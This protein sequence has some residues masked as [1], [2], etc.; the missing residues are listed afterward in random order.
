MTSRGTCYRVGDLSVDPGVRR[1]QRG[2]M[3]LPVRGLSF[4]LLLALMDAAPNLLSIDELMQRVWPGVVVS[5][6]TVSQRIKL[7]RHA[8]GDHPQHARYIVGVRGRG[9]RLLAPVEVIPPPQETPER[10]AHR[11]PAPA[12]VTAPA[13]ATTTA[14]ATPTTNAGTTAGT[15]DQTETSP[16]VTNSG[17]RT[18]AR[19]SL[20]VLA[21]LLAGIAIAIGFTTLSNTGAELNGERPRSKAEDVV[22]PVLA[23]LPFDAAGR[24]DADVTIPAG[25]HADVIREL[26]RVRSIEVIAHTSVS[27]FKDTSL[28]TREIGLRLGAT[29]LLEGN[30]RQSGDRLRIQA[31]LIEASTERQLWADTYERQ[32][33]ATNMF[34]AQ[35]QIA[36]AVANAL[37]VSATAAEQSAAAEVPTRN[38]D[39]WALEKTARVQLARRTTASITA[40]EKLFREAIAIDRHYARAYAGLADAIWLKAD[41]AGLPWPPA[42]AE[43]ERLAKVALRI[44]PDLPE[45]LTTLAKIAE[46]QLDYETAEALYRRVFELNPSY[47][48]AHT[49]YSQLMYQQGRE[50]E[51]RESTKR[52][53]ALDP[54]S[55]PLRVNMGL[56]VAEPDDLADAIEWMENAREIEPTSPIGASGMAI[57]FAFAGRYDEALGW[58]LAALAL[59]PQAAG[60]LFGAARMHLELDNLDGA[61]TWFAHALEKGRNI[62]DTS[63][64]AALLK[65]Y[66]DA[67]SDAVQLARHALSISPWEAPAF[68]VLNADAFR[69]VDSAGVVDAVQSSYPELFAP[70]KPRVRRSSLLPATD[71]ALA[72]QRIGNTQRAGELLAA[73]SAFLD[74]ARRNGSREYVID[75]I[76]ID[77]IRRQDESALNALEELVATGWR[78]PYWRFYRDH[79]AAFDALRADARFQKAFAV[80]EQEIQSQRSRAN[81]SGALARMPTES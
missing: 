48:M 21:A 59:E 51:A 62:P 70:G 16:S 10:V 28:R 14:T 23:V 42:R 68:M 55:A 11:S 81:R 22:R 45:A 13:P 71:L 6:E 80:V 19:K 5:P 47:A 25:L 74:V 12:I 30:V 65:L 54:M 56:A 18:G 67:R 7:L 20:L 64:H 53:V 63:S 41:Y 27:R 46:D 79:D 38:I 69:R 66:V 37:Q 44:D 50:I 26:S 61:S 29:H 2:D 4:D 77:A 52:A 60:P 58:S 40:A 24:P 15:S 57:C 1:V 34:A 8:L 3:E 78:G 33:T 76:R 75:R 43:A 72:F 35:E 36:L 32:L 39:A 73:A 31:R 9:Y 49:W 17:S